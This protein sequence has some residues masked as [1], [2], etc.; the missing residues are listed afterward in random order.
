MSNARIQNTQLDND[1]EL[2]TRIPDQLYH[3][4]DRTTDHICS[5]SLKKKGFIF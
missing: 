3:K 2:T 1:A 5:F 4:N